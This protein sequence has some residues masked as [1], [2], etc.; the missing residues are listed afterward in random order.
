MA[1]FF[2]PVFFSVK[3][4]KFYL[5]QV[6]LE[7]FNIT[8]ALASAKKAS[9]LASVSP[10]VKWGDRKTYLRELMQTESFHMAVFTPVGPM[11]ADVFS[12]YLC[13][14]LF[15]SVCFC[16]HPHSPVASVL[17]KCLCP[18]G[19][20]GDALGSQ[21]GGQETSAMTNLFLGSVL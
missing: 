3:L 20:H 6:L 7:G 19:G 18:L 10:S 4:G 2:G 14:S 15:T 16:L 11:V 8:L 13:P 1:T 17:T 21:C 9:L 12:P 5:P